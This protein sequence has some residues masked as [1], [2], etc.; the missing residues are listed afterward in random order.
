MEL[1]VTFSKQQ[2]FKDTGTFYVMKDAD[3]KPLEELF[4]A[5]VFRFLKKEGKITDEK[6]LSLWEEDT[7]R[8]PPQSSEISD[9]IVYVSIEDTAW[10]SYENPDFSG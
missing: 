6:Y 8:A 9:D 3:L 7:T 2:L 4:R 1:S 10:H 5:E